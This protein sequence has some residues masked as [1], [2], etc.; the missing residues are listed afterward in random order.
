[1]LHHRQTETKAVYFHVFFFMMFKIFLCSG[2]SQRTEATS[3]VTSGSLSLFHFSLSSEQTL[4]LSSV[5]DALWID[6]S[7]ATEP[8]SPG[9]STNQTICQSTKLDY[10]KSGFSSGSCCQ[11]RPHQPIPLPTLSTPGSSRSGETNNDHQLSV[12][13]SAM[14]D[15]PCKVKVKDTHTF[16]SGSSGGSFVRLLLVVCPFNCPS[17]AR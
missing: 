14:F 1:M 9:P 15:P 5:T 11:I 4:H 10:R 6:G 8:S 17:P 13:I 3:A 12:D 2:V 16:P 7:P